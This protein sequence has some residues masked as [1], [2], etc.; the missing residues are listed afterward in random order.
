MKNVSEKKMLKVF[1]D[2]NSTLYTKKTKELRAKAEKLTIVDLLKANGVDLQLPEALEKTLKPALE[3][4]LNAEPVKGQPACVA[5][6]GCA[7]CTL[8]AEVNFGAGIVG[9]VGTIAFAD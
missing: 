7:A 8:C 2:I 6:S 9:L 5:C 3:A 1:E 4:D